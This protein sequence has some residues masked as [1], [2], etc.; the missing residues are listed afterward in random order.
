MTLKNVLS[1][2]GCLLG[3]FIALACSNARAQEDAPPELITK[4]YPV[5][6]LVFV[7]PNYPYLGTDAPQP[8]SNQ[9]GAMGGGMG[10]S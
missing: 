7:A 10:G 8:Q 4:V 2:T 1:L 6:D 9:G 5:G 3:L